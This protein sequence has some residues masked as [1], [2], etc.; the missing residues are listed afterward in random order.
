M[1]QKNNVII[2]NIK[3]LENL[4][5]TGLVKPDDYINDLNTLRRIQDN[6]NQDNIKQ[7]RLLSK[8]LKGFSSEALKQIDEYIEQL[9]YQNQPSKTDKTVNFD[10]NNNEQPKDSNFNQG[11]AIADENQAINNEEERKPAPPPT[12]PTPHVIQNQFELGIALGALQKETSS[13][14]EYLDNVVAKQKDLH[15]LFCDEKEMFLNINNNA[16]IMSETMKHLEPLILKITPEISRAANETKETLVNALAD[17]DLIK[18]VTEHQ[19]EV[20]AMLKKIRDTTNE[21]INELYNNVRKYSGTIVDET[22]EKSKQE[23]INLSVNAV[24][25]VTE[26]TDKKYT[27]LLI[28]GL[29][30]AFACSLLTSAFTAKLV[31]TYSSNNTIDYIQRWVNAVAEK[32]NEHQQQKKSKK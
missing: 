14:K 19:T 13:L 15:K 28:F 12:Q 18:R 23:V 29:L 8:Q 4:I 20:D 21:H 26:K 24:K 5:Q 2:Q 27:N 25:S 9:I 10:V 32:S 7:C 16:G 6:I 17:K 1:S 3:D 11:E 31:A 30:G 22:I